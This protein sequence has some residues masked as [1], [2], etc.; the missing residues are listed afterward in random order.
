MAEHVT[1]LLLPHH[2]TV[3]CT[4]GPFHN[5][6]AMLSCLEEFQKWWPQPSTLATRPRH[7]RAADTRE[8]KVEEGLRPVEVRERQ[9]SRPDGVGQR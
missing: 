5:G 2:R 7:L 8:I 4:T 9:E 3:Q 6:R 1:D